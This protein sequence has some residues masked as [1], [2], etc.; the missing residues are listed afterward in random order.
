MRP[1]ITVTSV[2]PMYTVSYIQT[3]VEYLYQ[4]NNAILIYWS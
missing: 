1:Q 4:E 2:H 3:R